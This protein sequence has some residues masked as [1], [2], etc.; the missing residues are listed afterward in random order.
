MDG[1]EWQAVARG[2]IRRG[3]RGIHDPKVHRAL[4]LI[5]ADHSQAEIAHDLGMS[6]KGVERMLANQRTRLRKLGIA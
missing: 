1:P 6:E 2:Y 5:A 3:M 4:E